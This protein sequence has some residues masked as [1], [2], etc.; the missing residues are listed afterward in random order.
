M[1]F[2]MDSQV[3]FGKPIM[4]DASVMMPAPEHTLAAKGAGHVTTAGGQTGSHSAGGI[5]AILF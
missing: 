1:L 3:S 5:D 4:K 2:W